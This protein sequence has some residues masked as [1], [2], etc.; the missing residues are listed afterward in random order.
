M[1]R[2]LHKIV[3]IFYILKFNFRITIYQALKYQYL[4][5][6]F[7]FLEYEIKMQRI[8]L[9]SGLQWPLCAFLFYPNLNYTTFVIMQLHYGHKKFRF[10]KSCNSK[11]KFNFEKLFK[12]L[13]IKKMLFKKNTLE[14]NDFFSFCPLY[15]HEHKCNPNVRTNRSDFLLSN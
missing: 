11:N 10:F 9:Y 3:I 12:T 2:S 1:E 8:E 6:T 5:Y 14:I 13:F 7:S 4:K 15:L